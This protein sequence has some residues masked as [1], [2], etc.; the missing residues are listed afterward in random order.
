MLTDFIESEFAQDVQHQQARADRHHPAPAQRQVEI[1]TEAKAENLRIQFPLAR[2][3]G[4]PAKL[5]RAL[6]ARVDEAMLAGLYLAGA[7]PA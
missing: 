2:D 5:H 3:G 6:G 1:G 7:R 4:R